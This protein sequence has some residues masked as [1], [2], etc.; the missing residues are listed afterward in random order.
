LSNFDAPA[1]NM[2]R[3]LNKRNLV[4]GERN[5]RKRN[6]QEPA[7]PHDHQNR[8]NQAIAFHDP[9]D[10]DK[11]LIITF[12]NHWR[13][14]MLFTNHAITP[15]Q[16]GEH[17]YQSSEHYYMR[18]KALAFGLGGLADT[19]LKPPGDNSHHT[20]KDWY[21][22]KFLKTKMSKNEHLSFRMR[23]DVR[24]ARQWAG[25]KLRAMRDAVM[26]KYRQNPKALKILL[27][28][29]DSYLAEASY[30]KYWGVGMEEPNP[31]LKTLPSGSNPWPGQNWLGRILMDVRQELRFREKVQD[32][33]H[34]LA[35][36]SQALR[37]RRA[38]HKANRQLKRLG[39]VP[40][41]VRPPL[42]EGAVRLRIVP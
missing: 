35:N 39:K 29:G 30:D 1:I 4:K 41:A 42:F 24:A 12:F 25:T 9:S 17:R 2:G 16:K 18:Q 19:I 22:P 20:D 7:L 6:Q 34:P 38:R 37:D 14:D 3:H 27:D 13:A 5:A 32:A 28:T 40:A 36:R 33:S 8:V 15:F 10:P 11:P 26:A 31:R 23:T 21:N